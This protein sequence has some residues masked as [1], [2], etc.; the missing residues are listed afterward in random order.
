MIDS[1]FWDP[2]RPP[3]G[4][5]GVDEEQI[6][7]W[8]EQ[9]GILL[10][11]TLVQALM[12]QNG[13]CVAGTDLWIEPLQEFSPLSEPR[14]D[15]VHFEDEECDDVDRAKLF[16]IG[17]TATG[18]GVVLDGNAQPEPRVL[19]LWH[20]LGG[21]MRDEGDVTFDDLVAGER[22]LIGEE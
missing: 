16:A 13:G 1:P 15:H 6:R 19:F 2:E 10:P 20:D 7:D 21:E 8:E 18:L 14:W 3:A 17:T 5:D 9:R 22:G 11:S 4:L 12:I